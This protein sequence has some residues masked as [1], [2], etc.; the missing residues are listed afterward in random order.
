MGN[1]P[2]LITF[3]YGKSERPEG[4]EA[5]RPWKVT[6]VTSVA[7][8]AAAGRPRHRGTPRIAARRRAAGRSARRRAA[9][10]AARGCAAVRR[11]GPAGGGAVA[12]V[13][14]TWHRRLG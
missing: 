1:G 6:S 7:L 12:A 9:R 4:Y 14:D 8:A 11:A 2:V 5:L 10:I 3:S 13:V